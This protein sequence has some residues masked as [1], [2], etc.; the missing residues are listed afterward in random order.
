MAKPL[1]K[2]IFGVPSTEVRDR[3]DT[4]DKASALQ[5]ASYRFGARMR[6]LEGYFDAKA[7][8]A[9]ADYLAEAEAIHQGGAT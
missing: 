5:A 9:R 6:E 8:E 3:I 7:A 2:P 4:S 1:T